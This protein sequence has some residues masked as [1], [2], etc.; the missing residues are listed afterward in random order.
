[1]KKPLILCIADCLGDEARA[2][3]DA[4]TAGE[5]P[6]DEQGSISLRIALMFELSNVCYRSHTMYEE[7]EEDS[8][9]MITTLKEYPMYVRLDDGDSLVK[10]VMHRDKV[11]AFLGS[12]SGSIRA[13]CT[14]TPDGQVQIILELEAPQPLSSEPLRMDEHTFP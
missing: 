1:M 4:A 11:K 9:G 13:T 10:K 12:L 3:Q 8:P 6:E 7:Q 5:F 14:P 2:C